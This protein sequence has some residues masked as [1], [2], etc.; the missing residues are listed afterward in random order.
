VNRAPALLACLIAA[1]LLAACAGPP[2]QRGDGSS[3]V[4]RF[5]ILDLA[6]GDIDTVV[7]IHQQEILA[8]LKALTLKLYRRDPA[9]WRKSGH[10]SAA[11]ATSSLF[12]PVAAWHVSAQRKL[13]WEASLRD[14]WREDYAGDRVQ[15]LMRGLLTMQM[16]AFGHRTEFYLLSE[17]DAQKLYN[18]AR[19]TEAVALKLASAQGTP[20]LL[21][22][23][24]E[25]GSPP[26]PGYERELGQIIGVGDALAKVVEDKTNRA[27]RFGVVN[28]ASMIFLPI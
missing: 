7:E 26:E 8:S 11:A 28:F 5:T 12:A 18:A 22:N 15:A 6:K 14:A 13:D 4:R 17:I 9:E 19:N 21:A 20:L 27:I 25:P 16:A 24:P 10:A 1:A 23:T 2:I 3:S